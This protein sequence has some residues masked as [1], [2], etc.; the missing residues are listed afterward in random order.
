MDPALART[1]DRIRSA[2]AQ[3]QP[4]RI[5]GGGTK[6]FYGEQLQGDALE[7]GELRGI[8]SYDPASW[9]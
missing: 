7:T 9:W 4:L 5:R 1:V 3:G 8:V 2:A 6:D